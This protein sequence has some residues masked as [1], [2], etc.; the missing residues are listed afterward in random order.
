MQDSKQIKVPIPVGVNISPQQYPK[1]QEEEE[2][3]SHV[4]YAS[5]VGSLTMQ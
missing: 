5:S 1:S 2:D 4:P 3:M